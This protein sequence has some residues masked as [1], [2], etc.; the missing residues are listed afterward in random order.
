MDPLDEWREGIQ[1]VLA[2]LE[3]FEVPQGFPLDFSETSLTRLERLL[4]DRPPTPSLV[5]SATAYVG[6]TLL[7][8]GGGHWAWADDQPTIHPD[9]A[10]GLPPITPRDLVVRAA[11]LAATWATLTTAVAEH[12][13]AHP[14]W[15]PAKEPTPGMG[16]GPRAAT[17]PWLTDWL[18]ER[19]KSFPDWAAA[20]GVD[21]WD[22]TAGT[23][24]T[25]EVVLRERLATEEAFTDPRHHDFLQGAVWYYGEVACRTR[26]DARWQYNRSEPGSP[27]RRLNAEHNPWAGRPF[28]DQDHPGGNATVPIFDLESAVLDGTPGYLIARLHTLT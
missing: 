13:S 15:S 18:A 14:G 8:A 21:G 28:I 11:G 22:F 12:R 4:L 9:E 3:A 1:P 20:T 19:E 27:D 17:L 25:L 6:E 26:P 23:V 16:D 10:L 2:R 7:R 5:E 24:D